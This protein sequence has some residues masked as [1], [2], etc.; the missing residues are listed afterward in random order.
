MAMPGRWV[1]PRHE[2]GGG[3]IRQTRSPTTLQRHRD[4]ACLPMKVLS[5]MAP[6][7]RTGFV[8]GPLRLAGFDCEAAPELTGQD[9][10]LP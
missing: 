9:L 5:G 3:S 8:E 10:P 7:E 4:P 2:L 6:G 1:R